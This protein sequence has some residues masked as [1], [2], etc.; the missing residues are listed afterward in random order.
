DAL[1][2]A[3]LPGY[4][5]NHFWKRFGGALM[6]SLVDDTARFATQG[7]G[8]SGSNQFNFNSTGE[9]SSN[10][11]AEALKNTINIPPTLYKNQ[12]E[13]IAIFIARDLDF[14]SVYDVQTR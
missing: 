4:V 9:A 7:N 1:G 11:A 14:S 6:L 2:G 10:M 12:G 13:Q 5:D 3:G 8:S